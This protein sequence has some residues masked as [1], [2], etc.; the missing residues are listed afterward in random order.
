[1]ADRA[2]ECNRLR[3]PA[4][5]VLGDP[6][7]DASFRLCGREAACPVY[8]CAR[9]DAALMAQG[10]E[11]GSVAT[12]EA[13]AAMQAAW[14]SWG[15]QAGVARAG[16]PWR[17]CRPSD[18]AKGARPRAA[19][20]RGVPTAR[21]AD[22]LPRRLVP[23]FRRRRGVLGAWAASST[24]DCAGLEPVIARFQHRFPLG[25][26]ATSA[27]DE[28]LRLAFWSMLA[29]YVPEVSMDRHSP[30]YRVLNVDELRTTS[31]RPRGSPAG[32]LPAELLVWLVGADVAG[33]RTLADAWAR[34]V[35]RSDDAA[36]ASVENTY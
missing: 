10:G 14:D 25:P 34:V 2:D 7:D 17:C 5:G 13:W 19:S 36:Y 31:D 29:R 15:A 16:K 18:Q 11:E 21:A 27:A 30:A 3:C 24:P 26:E 20:L 9:C 32:P 23:R 1:M 22:R 4:C 8:R 35:D 28:L 33:E 12:P 6:A